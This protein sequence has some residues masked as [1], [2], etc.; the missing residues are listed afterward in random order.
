[1]RVPEGMTEQEVLD[2]IEVVVAR[3]CYKYKFGYHEV[4]DIKQLGRVFAIEGL[5]SYDGVRP[6]ENFLAIHVRNRLY[7]EK[8]NK[9]ER[10]EKPCFSCPFYDPDC[11]LSHNECTEYSDKEECSLFKGWSKRNSAKKSLMHTP[12]WDHAADLMPADGEAF[13]IEDQELLKRLERELPVS[14]MEDWTRLKYGLKMQKG[15]KQRLLEQ[16]RLIMETDN[17]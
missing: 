15:R 8:R 14:F 16:I 1:M 9:Y 6:L 7:N 11:K 13:E 5:E 3:L 12:S 17:E 4:D 2:T 10:H